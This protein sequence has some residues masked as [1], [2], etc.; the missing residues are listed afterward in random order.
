MDT[1]WFVTNLIAGL[2]LPP[3]NCLLLAAAGAWL[4][5][6][7]PRL[8]R[9]LMV[10]AFAGLWL[11][12]TPLVGDRLLGALQ[13]P[14]RPIHGIEAEAIVILGGGSRVAPE[15]GGN[16]LKQA[17]LER[18][19][20]GARLARQTGKPIL[21]TGGAPKGG[22]PEAEVMAKLLAEEF[23]MPVAWVEGRS[24]DTW[25]NARFS[26]ELLKRANIRRIYLVSQAWH[27]PRAVPAFEQAG[28]EVVPAG[29]G[30]AGA[31]KLTPLDFLPDVWGLRDSHIAMHE[32][33]GLIWYRIRN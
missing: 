24:R 18:V 23:G 4:A 22:R 27:L 19:A 3:L 33:I 32:A 11:L 17:T 13:L 7:R 21:V 16:G 20:Y 30:Y 29:T 6:R 1:G 28:L 15:Y 10:A 9:G 25:E 2:L 5:R 12:A 8:G 26:A 14:Y 31:E